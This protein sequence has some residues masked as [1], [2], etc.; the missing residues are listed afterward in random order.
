MKYIK[1]HCYSSTKNACKLEFVDHLWLTFL[2]QPQSDIVVFEIINFHIY[3]I[4]VSIWKHR[5]GPIDIFIFNE[6]LEFLSTSI[7]ELINID[8]SLHENAI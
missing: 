4:L 3:N 5:I 7:I 1:F 2:D 6:E 8:D